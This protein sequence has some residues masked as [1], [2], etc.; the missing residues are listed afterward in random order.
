ML[1]GFLG[2]EDQSDRRAFA[3]LSFIFV[4]P[5]QVE[6]HLAFVGGL[7]L[8]ELELD[9]DEAAEEPVVEEKVLFLL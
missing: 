9:D 6:L 7:E 8:A 3:R 4:K 2:A 5:A 1:G